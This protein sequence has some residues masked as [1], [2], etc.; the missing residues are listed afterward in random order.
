MPA[1]RSCTTPEGKCLNLV[2]KQKTGWGCPQ[3]ALRSKV[4]S[5]LFSSGRFH[6]G[7]T[8]FEAIQV[9]VGGDIKAAIG[10]D[11]TAQQR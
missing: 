11:Q 3:P 9:G 6:R 5:Y 8:F 4:L 7:A 1:P 2:T 10:S